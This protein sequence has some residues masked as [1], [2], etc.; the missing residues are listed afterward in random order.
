MKYKHNVIA[1]VTR[2]ITYEFEF[3]AFTNDP[4]GDW[5]EIEQQAIEHLKDLGVDRTLI[6]VL[7]EE[8]VADDLTLLWPRAQPWR[9]G[10][11]D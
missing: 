4:D 2:T 1:T 5:D 10:G 6:E 7:D 11:V 8:Y 9:E 3:K